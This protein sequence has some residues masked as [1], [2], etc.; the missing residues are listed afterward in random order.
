MEATGS[1]WRPFNLKEVQASGIEFTGKYKREL[2]GGSLG[3]GGMYAFNNSTLLEGI[4]EDDPSVGYQLPYT[5]KHRA[6]VFA[7]LMIKSYRFS[8][9]N[10]FTG[11]RYGIGCFHQ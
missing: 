8:M 5:P 7:D 11:M 10:A 4:S 6:V 1:I 9:N 2:A 3:I